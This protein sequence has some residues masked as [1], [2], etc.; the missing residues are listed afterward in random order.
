MSAVV[1]RVYD[2]A[3]CDAAGV[4][5]DWERCRP[6]GGRGSAPFFTN[7]E[8]MSI[9]Q[10]P[11]PTCGGHGSLRAAA[12]AFRA[13]L[14][15]ETRDHPD[16]HP[17]LLLRSA[18][19]LARGGAPTEVRC[20]GCGHPM[21]DGT[22]GDRGNGEPLLPHEAAAQIEYALGELRAGDEPDMWE[23][24]THWSPCD[25]RCRHGGPVAERGDDGFGVLVESD[26]DFLGGHP[27]AATSLKV[28]SSWRQVD[29]RTLGWA[30]DLRP[31]N[32]TV[33]CLRCFAE[34]P[35]A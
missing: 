35:H 15:R 29:V 25:E 11:C 16:D 20:E 8:T 1:L 33:L 34:R 13:A 17:N 4:P 2:P 18:D 31:E 9:E 19:A 28:W 21:S 23:R 26:V 12:L 5:L 10:R 27:L 30:H 6:C 14:A 32:L 24:L 3:E 7:A 22:W